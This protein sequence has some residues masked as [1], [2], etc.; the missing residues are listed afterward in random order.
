VIGIPSTQVGIIAVQNYG[1]S[2]SIFLH[3]LLDSHPQALVL[4]GSYGIQYYVSWGIHMRR[5]TPS[6]IDAAFMRAWILEFFKGLYDPPSSHFMGL[7]ELGDDMKENASVDRAAFEKAFDAWVD[8]LIAERRLPGKSKITAQ[9]VD[10]YRTVCLIAVHLAYAELLGQDLSKKRWIVYPAHSAPMD[11][12]GPLSQDFADVRFVHMVREP[13]H[14]LD[15]MQRLLMDLARDSQPHLDVFSCVLHQMFYDRAPQAPVCGVPLYSIYPFPVPQGERSIAIRLEDLHTKSR[16]TLEGLCR[17]LKLDWDD[18][19]MQSTFAGKKWWSRPGMRRL[20]GFSRNIIGREPQFGRFDRWRLARIGSPI[21]RQYEY[22]G[23]DGV[24]GGFA[25]YAA[26]LLSIVLPFELEFRCFNV[27][28]YTGVRVRTPLLTP[29]RVQLWLRGRLPIPTHL[30]H[31]SV[32]LFNA[33]APRI[34]TNWLFMGAVATVIAPFRIVGDYVGRR[35]TIVQGFIHNRSPATR[36]VH[37]M[38]V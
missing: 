8:R 15:S 25:D 23:S 27:R 36:F 2:G 26:L 3:S 5:S 11:D 32:A 17:W 37:L 9:T 14:N 12:I 33:I 7:A 29:I 28:R 34:C 38:K 6:G 22:S 35:V 16:E 10:T 4:P 30:L 31:R 20:N 1:S 13:I 19:L 24:P 18:C 21:L